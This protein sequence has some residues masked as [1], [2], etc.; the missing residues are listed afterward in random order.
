MKSVIFD[1]FII[2]LTHMKKLFYLICILAFV[3]ISFAQE[4]YQKVRIFVSSAQ[5]FKFL[6]D[7]GIV[8][9]EFGKKD[10]TFV[11]TILS[12]YEVLK[13]QNLGIETE[14]LVDNIQEFYE[15]RALNAKTFV[16]GGCISPYEVP[17]NYHG[18]SM[19]G[20][21]NHDEIMEELDQMRQLYPNL[22][23]VKTQ[24]NNFL[25]EDGNRIYF[26]RI[27]DTPDQDSDKPEVLYTALHH[28]REPQSSE[29]LIFYMWYLLENYNSDSNIKNLV[30]N[31]E[32][33]F[34]PILNPDGFK[35][36][37]LTNPN[38][39][40]M[41]RKNRKVFPNATGVDINRNYGF[42]WGGEGASPDPS[43]ETYRGESAFSETETQTVKWFTEQHEFVA[44]LNA[45]TYS[46]LF[47]YPF[48]YEENLPTPDQFI[49][50][51]LGDH[52]MK[53]NGYTS[54]L[55]SELYVTSGGSD[56]WMYG[57][58]STKPKIFAFTPE[59]GS[60]FWPPQSEILPNNQSTVYT[61]LTAA[62]FSGTYV[63]F[64][65]S[66]NKFVES[67]DNV[68]N[69]KLTKIGTNGGNSAT[70]TLIPVSSN[71]ASVGNPFTQNSLDLFVPKDGQ[72]NYTLNSTI[73]PGDPIIFE[74]KVNNGLYDQSFMVT[75]YFGFAGLLVNDPSDNLNFWNA[76]GSWN[77]TQNDLFHLLVPLPILQMGIMAITRT[78]RLR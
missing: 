23:S 51:N 39:F 75:K 56:D 3:P 38:G 28:A 21:L 50:E 16:N 5:E 65:D 42:Q 17:E 53:D 25:T 57:D 71:I 55:S 10:K 36:N 1:K 33:Y 8:L 2:K 46:G 64:E 52:F 43:S 40:G 48:G 29:Q 49:F 58:A 66:S 44:A 74:V 62:R 45:H 27:S 20:F 37:E 18:G 34:I 70:V 68:L 69:F 24:I 22:I 31:T 7:N 73:Q 15:Q 78:V 63:E 32:M 47:L 54:Q 19:A 9:T 4:K 14:L 41:W 26:V 72:M 11:E 13:I 6:S 35:Y 12:E 77:T 59:L 67:L 30:D 60:D 76:T 61:N